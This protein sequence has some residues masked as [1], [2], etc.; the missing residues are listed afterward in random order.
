[1]H[2]DAIAGLILAGG[3][4]SRMG[5][6][7]KSLLELDGK[8]VLHHI[9]GR[10]RP[11]VATLALNANGHLDR[12]AAFG[13]P[14]LP[15]TVPGFPGPLAGVLAGLEWVEAQPSHRTLMTV[16]GDTPFLPCDLAARLSDATRNDPQAIAVAGSGGRE[17]PVFA[18]W[19]AGISAPL[20]AYLREGGRKVF[21]FVRSR[22]FVS[23]NFDYEEGM[24]PF[25]NIN[26]PDDLA[27]AQRLMSGDRK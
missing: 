8:P 22:P 1:M 19:P 20:R 27:E 13:L 5:G 26:T 15:D 18:L 16:A 3:L 21:D 2:D 9:I 24:D 10:I 25:F 7:D 23:V 11:Q 12:F 14:V 4:S 17:H 6:G